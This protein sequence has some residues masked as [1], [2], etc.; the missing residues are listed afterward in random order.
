MHAK[1]AGVPRVSCSGGALLSIDLSRA[2]DTVPRRA[3][4]QA[5]RA[6]GVDSELHDL[7]L[8]L[9]EHCQYE[10]SQGQYADKFDMQ[11][12]VRQGCSLSPL[13]YA[14]FTGWVYD[15]IKDRTNEAW[16]REFITMYAD[17]TVL[18]WHVRSVQD[19][20][21]MCRSVQHTFQVLREIGMSVNSSKS[22]VIIKPQGPQAKAWLRKHLF[23][24][25]QGQV[26][27]LGTPCH[28][29]DVPRVHSLTYLGVE[30]SLA[31]FE[32][33]TCALRLRMSAQIKH[34][35]VKVLHTAKLGLQHRV[36]LYQACLR[37]SMPYGQH[38]VG[39]NMAVLRRLEAADARHLRGI[40]RSPAH[41]THE[42]SL[43]LRQRL[44][45]SSPQQALI[46]MLQRR[47]AGSTDVSSRACFQELLQWLKNQLQVDAHEAT[48]RLRPVDSSRHIACEVCGQY[49]GSMQHLLSH[50][51]RKHPDA[52][53]PAATG[54]YYEHTVDGMP[55]CRHC[56]AKFNRLLPCAST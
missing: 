23:R 28:P 48:T 19:L 44:R 25:P 9:H 27:R 26:L 8:D 53:I 20:H 3:L 13:L 38:A 55:E 30:A 5:L 17:D 14:I 33:Q 21:F 41:L 54:A 56:G 36:R 37:S 6:A 24:T 52:T 45:I 22:K 16:A 35:L 31:G 2:F 47:T 4:S 12:G 43:H 49:F 39:L 34:R 18:Q 32:L 1:R 7:V 29:I 10:I 15:I 40:A 42:S 51:A 11:C 46:Q 50:H